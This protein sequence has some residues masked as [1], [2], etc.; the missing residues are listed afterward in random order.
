MKLSYLFISGALLASCGV[1]KLD[2]NDE[3]NDIK[4]TQKQSKTVMK[5]LT[6]EQEVQNKS[7]NKQQVIEE[8]EL[9]Q[10]K[11]VDLANKK[12]KL[13]INLFN[14]PEGFPDDDRAAL[15][16]KCYPFSKENEVFEIPGAEVGKSYG[17]AL[18][19]DENNNENLDTV[20]VL[21]IPKE[22]YGFSNNPAFR[23]GAPGYDEIEF[24][25]DA[26]PYQIEIDLTYLL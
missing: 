5:E 14:G 17:I 16:S 20:G 11:I 26:L 8:A 25:V 15:H 4:T 6:E 23:A 19:H 21:G 10:I 2:G 1:D 3:R 7:N 22:G 24:T 12:G 13:C 9:L 18:F